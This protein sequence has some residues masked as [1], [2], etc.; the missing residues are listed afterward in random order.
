MKYQAPEMI[1]LKA[2]LMAVVLL[3]GISLGKIQ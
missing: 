2:L 3:Y 1:L